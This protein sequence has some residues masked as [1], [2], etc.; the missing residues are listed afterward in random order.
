MQDKIQR[1]AKAAAKRLRLQEAKEAK[2]AKRQLQNNIREA[3]KSKRNQ[4]KTISAR[5]EVAT[6]SSSRGVGV[7]ESAAQCP[8]RQKSL[9]Q[10]LKNYEIDIA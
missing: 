4:K 3:R 6:T 7:V 9:P 10:H 8:Q 2:A 5:E 1:D